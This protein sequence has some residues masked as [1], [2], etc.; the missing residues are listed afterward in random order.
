MTINK[1]NVI[2]W[3]LNEWGAYK[4]CV[5]TAQQIDKFTSEKFVCVLPSNG[6]GQ[7]QSEQEPNSKMQNQAVICMLKRKEQ[8][9]N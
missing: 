2:T 3:I 7:K 9:K 1:N 5:C 8:I 4:I 6:W